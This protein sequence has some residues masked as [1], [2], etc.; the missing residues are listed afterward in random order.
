MKILQKFL[1]HHTFW[2]SVKNSFKKDLQIK[3]IRESDLQ[4]PRNIVKM[5]QVECLNQTFQTLDL[6][7]KVYKEKWMEEEERIM[8]KVVCL[9]NSEDDSK[10]SHPFKI[11]GADLSF[12]PDNNQKAVCC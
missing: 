5:D 6:K 7:F 11:G 2:L 12:I 9:P 4:S 3:N 10:I 8:K 1:C